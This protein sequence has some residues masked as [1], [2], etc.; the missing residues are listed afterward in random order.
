MTD[1][2]F[3][4]DMD[5]DAGDA[6]RWVEVERRPKRRSPGVVLSVRIGPE[7]AAALAVFARQRGV[8]VSDAARECLTTC[9]SSVETPASG[10]VWT[11][12]PSLRQIKASPRSGSA[13]V[14]F[15]QSGSTTTAV[16]VTSPEIEAAPAS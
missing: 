3:E 10:I 9:V 1:H 8:S 16:L 7:V 11:P 12:D 5:A 13:W 14:T 4:P 6:T 2:A 15:V